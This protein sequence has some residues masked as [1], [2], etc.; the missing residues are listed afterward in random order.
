MS[1]EKKPLNTPEPEPLEND[2][3]K[4][5]RAQH[6]KQEAQPVAQYA[7]SIKIYADGRITYKKDSGSIIGATARVD[8]SGSKRVFRDTR[9][10][11]LIIEGPDVGMAISL[12]SK[13]HSNQKHAQQFAATINSLAARLSR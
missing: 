5:T 4:F 2:L 12:A 6:K 10:V 7:P 11:F 1:L 13:G 3:Y 9:E 8:S